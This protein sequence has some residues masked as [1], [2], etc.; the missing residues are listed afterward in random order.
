MEYKYLLLLNLSRII[1][2]R[3]KQFSFQN[4]FF[5]FKLIT[6]VKRYNFIHPN[7]MTFK[8]FSLLYVMYPSKLL[9]I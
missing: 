3:Y 5:L 1:D 9:S 8:A 2:I 7:K 4:T 6:C